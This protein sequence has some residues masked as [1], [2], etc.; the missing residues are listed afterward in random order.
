M[1]DERKQNLTEQL[2]TALRLMLSDYRTEGCADPDC[3]VC[4][5]SKKTENVAK[6]ALTRWKMEA[7]AHAS[8]SP[9]PVN[10]QSRL[11]FQGESYPLTCERCGLGPC[12]FFDQD[13]KA[14]RA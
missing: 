7:T 2:V 1:K 3:M 10:C 9:G 8:T 6:D 5:Q 12:P 4:A 11:R 14:V 13:G